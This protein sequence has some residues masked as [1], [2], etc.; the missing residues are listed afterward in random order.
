MKSLIKTVVALGLIAVVGAAP[1][2][3]EEKKMKNKANP[4][5]NEVD[6]ESSTASE[7]KKSL[8]ASENSASKIFGLMLGSVML[9]AGLTM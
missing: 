7:A 4:N 8:Q 3:A 1:S 5:A 6:E 2:K 9:I